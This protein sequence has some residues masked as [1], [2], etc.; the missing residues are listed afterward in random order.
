VADDIKRICERIEGAAL[1]PETWPDVLHE[2]AA[3]SGGAGATILGYGGGRFSFFNSTDM[4]PGLAAAYEA[5]GGAD[6]ARNPRIAATLAA[7]SMRVIA[8]PEFISE[9]ERRRHPLY[10]EF[11]EPSGSHYLT[12]AVLEAKGDHRVVACL[13]NTRDQGP[14]QTPQRALFAALLP[15]LQAAVRLQ[16]RL[17]TEAAAFALGALETLGI[18]ALFCNFA[19]RVVGLTAV[20]DALLARSDALSLRDGRLRATSAASDR[21]LREAVERAASHA[22]LV[23]PRS[24]A[25]LLRDADGA[26]L[27]IAHVAPLPASATSLQTGARVLVTVGLSAPRSKEL[28]PQLGLSPA[29]AEIARALAD[30]E[31]LRD[32]AERRKVSIETV[33]TQ[34]RA[35]YGKLGVHRQVELVKRLRDLM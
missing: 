8:E 13:R 21:A 33:R 17:E 12:A 16:L 20:A 7:P 30:G 5:L 18:A 22:T 23:A 32:I 31:T 25:V 19:G 1:A 24:G 34:L 6:A 10:Q 3:A 15:H 29:E 14:P 11:L 35:V 4:P 28:P 9:D 26:P 2:I 27:H